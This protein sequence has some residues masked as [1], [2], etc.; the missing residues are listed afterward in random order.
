MISRHDIVLWVGAAIV[1]IPVQLACM[2]F[3][4]RLSAQFSPFLPKPWWRAERLLPTIVF[5]TVLAVVPM[6]IRGPP[7]WS[8][9]IKV[10]VLTGAVEFLAWV[11]LAFAR[12][13][14]SKADCGSGW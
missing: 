1:A 9:A 7:F 10:I 6:V 4:Y 3:G 8:K 13:K 14:R 2:F 5:G 12:S 11:A